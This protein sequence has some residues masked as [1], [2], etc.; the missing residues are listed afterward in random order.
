MPHDIHSCY[1]MFSPGVLKSKVSIAIC[2][3]A[4]SSLFWKEKRES[5]PLDGLRKWNIGFRTSSLCFLATLVPLTTLATSLPSPR[6]SKHLNLGLL[7][8][9]EEVEILKVS[10]FSTP[11]PWLLNQAREFFFLLL[12]NPYTRWIN[13]RFVKLFVDGSWMLN[14]I[15][16]CLRIKTNE[17]WYTQ[18]NNSDVLLWTDVKV[19]PLHQV[20]IL[21]RFPSP[22][23]VQSVTRE[24]VM[25]F[26]WLKVVFVCF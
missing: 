14:Y 3:V 10:C 21:F 26:E 17:Y 2:N 22:S 6:S 15:G 16:T 23:S 12:L 24:L 11:R 20:G 4:L 9:P 7:S 8:M 1:V 18:H 5:T 13:F 19:L 25:T